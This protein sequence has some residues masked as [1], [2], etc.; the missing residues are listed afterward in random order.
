MDETLQ[1]GLTKTERDLLLRGLRFVRSSVLFDM[2]DPD[3]GET[4]DRT[5]QLKTI[6][7]LAEQLDGSHPAGAT[8]G[9]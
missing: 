8:A 9:V 1:V 5:E 6:T 4:S 3:P 2:R 7:A